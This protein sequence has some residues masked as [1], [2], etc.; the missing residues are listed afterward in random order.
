MTLDTKSDAVPKETLQSNDSS[1]TIPPFKVSPRVS[2]LPGDLF[3]L[4]EG[5]YVVCSSGKRHS[6]GERGVFRFVSHRTEPNGSV[7]VVARRTVDVRAITIPWSR[8]AEQAESPAGNITY[9]PYK[10]RKL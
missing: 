4:S 9:R 2:L 7:I 10:V 8:P 3:R 1:G 5:P 6:F